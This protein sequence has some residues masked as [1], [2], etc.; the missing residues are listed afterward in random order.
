MIKPT[1]FEG[2]LLAVNENIRVKNNE[3]LEYLIEY[4]G[5][6]ED[7]ARSFIMKLA[8]KEVPILRIN[9]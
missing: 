8:R 1:Y 6:E 4:I 2:A 5:M 9:Y 3:L 7:Q